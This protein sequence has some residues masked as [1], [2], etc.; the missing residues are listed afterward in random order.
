[1]AVVYVPAALAHRPRGAAVSRRASGS[2]SGGQDRRREG[3]GPQQHQQPESLHRDEGIEPDAIPELRYM[4]S[5]VAG[6]IACGL[7]AAAVGQRVL[8][9]VRRP[10]G[11]LLAGRARGLL[12]VGVRLRAQPRPARRHQGARH[13]LPAAADRE[14]ADPQFHATSWPASGGWVLIVAVTLVVLLALGLA[15]GQGRRGV[16]R[17]AGRL[18]AA[19][20]LGAAALACATPGPVPIVLGERDCD[21]LPHDHRRPALRR[22]AGDPDRQGLPVR[23]RRVP[24]HLC[25]ERTGGGRSRSIRRGS[26]ISGSRARS[27]RRRTR[28]SSVPRRCSRRWRATCSPC[29]AP[30]ATACRPPSAARS[31]DWAQVLAAARAPA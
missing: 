10:P 17:A 20:L 7:L 2:R 28:S 4:P 23:R 27:S 13:D 19:A 3:P 16:R 25:R 30:P 26:A 6:L 14:Q 9:W 15:A 22:R 8:L 18:Q 12:Q 24:G 1:M 29:R 21:A 11:R 31:C 5:I